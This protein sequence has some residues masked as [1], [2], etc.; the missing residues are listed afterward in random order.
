MLLPN[1]STE[2]PNAQMPKNKRGKHNIKSIKAGTT[3]SLALLHV[4]VPHEGLKYYT[5]FLRRLAEAW[6][7]HFNEAP[8]EALLQTQTTNSLFW[9]EK[10]Q[11]LDCDTDFVPPV[12]ERISFAALQP[13]SGA[14]KSE[15]LKL[16]R[17]KLTAMD[18]TDTLVRLE[19][20]TELAR[21]NT[22]ILAAKLAIQ[23]LDMR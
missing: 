18:V 7:V 15:L 9:A 6:V 12:A 11:S 8:G 13:V 10:Q 2:L 5:G 3:E 4:I 20:A 14:T 23:S 17:E 19:K 21:D 22:A 1:R 16:Q